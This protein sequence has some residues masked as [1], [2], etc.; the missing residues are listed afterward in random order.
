MSR[1]CFGGMAFFLGT[2]LFFDLLVLSRECGND[3]YKPSP[4]DSFKEISGSFPAEHQQVDH[5]IG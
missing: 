4:L 2:S 3:P 1:V 5:Q